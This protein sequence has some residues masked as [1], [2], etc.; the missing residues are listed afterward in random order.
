MTKRLLAMVYNCPFRIILS[1]LCVLFYIFP[2]NSSAPYL[3]ESSGLVSMET[4]NFHANV[5]RGGLKWKADYTGGYS[6]SGAMQA[7]EGVFTTDYADNSP[8]LDY[9]VDFAFSGTH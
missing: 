2:E 7:P 4:E 5:S 3:Q 1:T 8:R 9:Q 6:G